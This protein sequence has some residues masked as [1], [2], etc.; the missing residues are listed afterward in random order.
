M[1]DLDPYALLRMSRAAADLGHYNLG[2]L[3]NAAAASL[4]NR[5]LYEESLPK[6]D[7]A[8]AEAVSQLEPALRAAGIDPQLLATIRHAREIIAA[9]NLIFYDDAPPGL[10]LPCVRRSD[11][12]HSA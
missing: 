8:L 7:R 12:A 11:A 9:G 10:G 6:T 4:V 5:S 1:P 2:K 3:L